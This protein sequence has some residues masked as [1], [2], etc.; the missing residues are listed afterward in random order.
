MIQVFH[1]QYADFVRSSNI[2]CELA[3]LFHYN[4]WKF[5]KCH[6]FFS[7]LIFFYYNIFG[8]V[9]GWTKSKLILSHLLKKKLLVF[10]R[11]HLLF[12]LYDLVN[13]LLVNKNNVNFSLSLHKL[14]Y[15][16]L[17]FKLLKHE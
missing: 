14:T 5:L 17:F 11:C 10:F 8:E 15:F 2:I 7:T 1:Y 4:F 12:Y 6:Y 16:N 13:S 9:E 3:H